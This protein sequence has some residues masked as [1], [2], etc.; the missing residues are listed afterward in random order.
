[1][2][3]AWLFLFLN[4]F[5]L[6]LGM[7]RTEVTPS[8]SIQQLSFGQ[9]VFSIGS[10]FANSMGQ[11]L[12]DHKFDTLSNPFGILFNTHAIRQA[13]VTSIQATTFPERLYGHHEE[14][15]FHYWTHSE[16]NAPS[17]AALHNALTTRVH[18][19]Q[20]YL[21]EANWVLL[22]LGT[23]WVYRYKKTGDL[24]ANCH[25]VP[26]NQFEKT[27]LSPEQNQQELHALIESLLS[28][29]PNCKIVLTVSPVRH[30]KDTLVLNNVSKASLLYAVHE[31]DKQFEA[32]QYFP[33]YELL[34]DDLRDYRFFA[35]DMLHPSNKAEEYIWNKFIQ[36]YVSEQDRALMA[37]WY[38]IRQGLQHRPFQIKSNA[39]DKFITNLSIKLKH[40]EGIVDIS[41]ELEEIEQIRIKIN[42]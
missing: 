33:S 32:V 38:K 4:F 3:I 11:R 31:I 10:C 40:F 24:V 22:T 1:M 15:H 17:K 36:T 42:E 25:K 16:C 23:S 37:E 8:P 41:S 18:N 13:L 28:I 2:Q 19:T 27:L 39:Y 35:D 21:K 7:F 5:T 20:K 14:R 6:F 34:L 26:N 12:K 30:I 29:N 9:K